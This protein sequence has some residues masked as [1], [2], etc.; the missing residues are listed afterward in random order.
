[1]NT[2]NIL[3]GTTALA[4]AALFGTPVLAGTVGSGDNLSVM[5]GGEYTFNFGLTDQDV[6]AG[7]GRGYSFRHD[8][9]EIYIDAA[10]TADNGI[11][12]GVS[13][14]LLANTDDTTAADEAWA[15]VES[16]SLGRLEM[17]HQDD[18]MTRVHVGGGA[19]LRGE[20]TRAAEGK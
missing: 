14:E 12:Y 17:G 20:R 6:S 2:R 15:F 18:A 13:I 4:T 3:L 19:V 7:R 9:V 16:D 8:D 5:L 10:N 1:M 11:A